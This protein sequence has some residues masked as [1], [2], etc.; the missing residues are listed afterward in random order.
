MSGNLETFGV[1]DELEKSA[2]AHS[3]RPVHEALLEDAN[4]AHM[5]LELAAHRAASQKVPVLPPNC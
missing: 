5:G 2:D 3:I 4:S 1:A